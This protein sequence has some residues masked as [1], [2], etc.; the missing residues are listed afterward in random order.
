MTQEA[1]YPTSGKVRL[2]ARTNL[3]FSYR[4]IKRSRMLSLISQQKVNEALRKLP[5]TPDGVTTRSTDEPDYLYD[6]PG[7][8]YHVL[9]YVFSL[10]RHS[11]ASAGLLFARGGLAAGGR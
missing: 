3:R 2:S 4:A 8:L 11:S 7:Y 1:E 10:S 5:S 6:V 9:P